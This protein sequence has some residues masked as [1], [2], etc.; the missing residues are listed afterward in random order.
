MEKY[1]LSNDESYNLYKM[2]YDI[3]KILEKNQ[4][5]YWVYAGT[6]L[7]AVRSGG[8]IKWD[9][10]LDIGIPIKYIRHIEEI[11]GNNSIY[12]LKKSRLLFKIYYK[13]KNNIEGKDYSHPFLD[14]FFMEK[15]GNNWILSFPNAR[16][17]LPNEY[18]LE[19]ELYPLKEYKFGAY[20]VK[21]PNKYKGFFDRNY[22]KDWNK[23]AVISYNHKK[24][25]II[26]KIEWK[27]RGRDFEAAFPFYYPGGKDKWWVY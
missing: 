8:I 18:F 16:R 15:R 3:I 12:G 2:L 22:G 21:G 24:E 10:D 20:K 7:G 13:D 27:M 1:F 6:F 19:G 4:I 14:I 25:K 26:K 5:E 17:L 9:D 11:F 23:K